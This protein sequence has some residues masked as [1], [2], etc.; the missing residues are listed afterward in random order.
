MAVVASDETEIE[1]SA[2]I[3]DKSVSESTDPVKTIVMV[4]AAV[5][6]DLRFLLDEA[7]LNVIIISA[8]VSPF[9]AAAASKLS[10]NRSSI[11]ATAVAY[12]S[13]VVSSRSAEYSTVVSMLSSAVTVT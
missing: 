3:E 11:S 4:H 9:S 8:T 12:A 5:A 13:D 6:V 2:S 7:S 1:M 10:R